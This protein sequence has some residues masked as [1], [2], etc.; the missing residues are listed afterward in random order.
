MFSLVGIIVGAE[1]I[2]DLSLNGL[3]SFRISDNRGEFPD[4]LVDGI[5]VNV[6]HTYNSMS[7]LADYAG[8]A[9]YERELPVNNLMKNKQLRVEFGAVYHDAE[10]YINGVK[11]GN[12][13]MPVIHRL[14]LIL[15]LM[16]ISTERIT[17]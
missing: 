8:T 14:V 4:S 13:G 9:V 16:L 17:E 1:E 11:A 15:P 10:I 2:T 7:E 6:P 5:L 3:W 12:I